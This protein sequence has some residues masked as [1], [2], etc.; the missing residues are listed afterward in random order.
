MMLIWPLDG[1]QITGKV[2]ETLSNKAHIPIAYNLQ[3]CLYNP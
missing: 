2:Q 1:T 3:A